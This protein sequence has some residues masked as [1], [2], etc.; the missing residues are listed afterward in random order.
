M[1]ARTATQLSQ[2]AR[3]II[4]AGRWL[5]ARGWAPA[6][7][8]NYS[9]RLDAS[10][11]AITVSGRHKGRLT[12]DDVMVVDS[13]GRPQGDQQP[14]AETALHAVM[15]RLDPAVE[16]VVHTHSI[17]GTILGMD[18][19]RD[20]FELEGYELLKVLPGIATHDTTVSLPIFD[21]TQDM[22][23]LARSV[24][25]RWERGPFPGYLIRGHGLYTWGSTMNLALR[26]VE[27]LEFLIACEI[28]R[29]KLRQ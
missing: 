25:D 22:T 29:R 9:V 16:A 27:A 23:V 19:D 6:T 4:G 1:D 14:S 10:R 5:D 18:D 11:I 13:E 24:I 20:T 21:N 2:A 12:A 3:E 15:Y 26:S 8:G 28:E 17:F 7:A